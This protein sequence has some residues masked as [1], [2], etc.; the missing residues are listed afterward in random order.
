MNIVSLCAVM[1]I[2]RNWSDSVIRLCGVKQFYTEKDERYIVFFTRP[3][4]LRRTGLIEGE[5]FWI[6]REDLDRYSL[7]S[8]KNVSSFTS[9]LTEQFTYLRWK[10][11]KDL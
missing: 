9:D 3:I 10:V 11:V 5:V 6:D 1:E 2:G 4:V 8:F 7:L